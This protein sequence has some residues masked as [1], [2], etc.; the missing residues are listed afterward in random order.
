MPSFLDYWGKARPVDEAPAAWHALAFHSLD[1]AAAAEALLAANPRLQ[2]LFAGWLGHDEA[3]CR[4]LLCGAAALHDLGKFTTPFQAKGPEGIAPAERARARQGDSPTGDPGHAHSGAYYWENWARIDGEAF[5]TLVLAANGHHGQPA[6]PC[7]ANR[8][9][10]QADDKAAADAFVAAVVELYGLTPLFKRPGPAKRQR[11]AEWLA[12]G[13]VNLADW[14][15]S[16]QA[17]F[18]YDT[19]DWLHDQS[20]SAVLRRY[21]AERARP[22]AAQAVAAKGLTPRPI[23]SAL[24]LGDLILEGG[25]ATP[26]QDWAAQVDLFPKEPG[27]RLA[28]LEDFT[29]AG[30]TEAALLLAHRLMAGGLAGPGL[31]WALPTQATSNALYGRLAQAYRRLF[32]GT[33]NPSLALAH[34][35]R[36]LHLPF[37]RTLRPLDAAVPDYD[38]ALP[39]AE[40]ACAAWLVDDRR[41]TFFAEIAVGTIDQALLAAMPSRFSVLRLLGLSQR[42]LVIDEVHSYDPYM[43]S[44]MKRLI[45][46]Q[47][48]LGG[49]TILLSAT[50]TS[51]LRD[52]LAASFAVS[53]GGMTVDLEE[54]GFPYAALIAPEGKVEQRMDSRRGTRRDLPVERLDDPVAAEARLLDVARAGG[55]AAYIRNTVDE[56]TESAARLRA[57]APD[58]QVDLFH[59]RFALCDRAAK[60]AAVL[61]AFGKTSTEAQRAGRILV[62]TQVVEQSLDLDFDLLASDLAPLDLL[63]QRAG[64][65]QRHERPWRSLPATL[66]LVGPEPRDGADGVWY[67]RLFPQGAYVYKNHGRLWAAMRRIVEDGGLLLARRN[68]RDLLD[69]VYELPEDAIPEGLR[70]SLVGQEQGADKAQ[71]QKGFNNA[72]AFDKGYSSDQPR[73]WAEEEAV[74]TRLSEES[75]QVRLATW[76]GGKLRPWAAPEAEDEGF[77]AWRRSELRLA[78][79]RFGEFLSSP[80]IVAAVRRVEAAWAERR[81]RSRLVVLEPQGDAA[82]SAEIASAKHGRHRVLYDPVEGWRVAPREE[83][84][85]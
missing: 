31:Y 78:P 80:E 30:K 21:W 68:P 47:T 73:A 40:A 26:L 65:L 20:N 18:P 38:G 32:A 5:T 70:N 74:Y 22:A 13:L 69:W 76:E 45:E 39:P 66:L 25:Q 85:A 72:L 50:M 24:T 34:G 43:N 67:S 33:G 6:D 19:G 41:T 29:G 60:E 84:D 52:D 71:A 53:S 11:H 54:R 55:C 35:G 16:D 12:A 8:R 10:W 23:A 75:L 81:D 82:W 28:L 17:F 59:A 37:R 36:D 77:Q 63:I 83:G 49:S 14:V 48:A 46:F 58:L 27:P 3:A 2:W 9:P 42:V 51:Q 56:A 79:N 1:V 57:A 15:G 4:A 44:L 64:R 62:A 61:A 7:L